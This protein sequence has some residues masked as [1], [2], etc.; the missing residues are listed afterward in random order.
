MKQSLANQSRNIR[1]SRNWLADYY[2]SRRKI[3]KL[4]FDYYMFLCRAHLKRN[5]IHFQIAS[6]L[7]YRLELSD[8]DLTAIV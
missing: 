7:I 1:F 4:K 5:D 3:V 8:S 2:R 6:A